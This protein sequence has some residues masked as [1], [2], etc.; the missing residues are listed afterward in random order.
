VYESSF[1]GSSTTKCLIDANNNIYILGIGT[2]PNGQVTKVKKISSSGLAV[3]SYFDS[4]IGGPITFKFTP[5]NKIVIVHRG[6]TGSLNGYSKIDLSGNNIW[7]IAG[8]ASLSVGDAAG[9]S[10]GNTFIINGGNPGS[11]L[12]KISP[13]GTILWT[14][15]NFINGNKV[16]V[17]T[18]N[19]PVV[20]GFASVGYGVAFMKY[21]NNGNVLWQNLDADGPGL[22]FLALAPMKL[23]ASNAAY[24][25]GSTMSLMG[26]CKVNSNGT[27]AWAATTSSGY[28]VC[29]DFGTD[30]SV[31][32]TGGTTARF[33]QAGAVQP[34]IAPTNLTAVASGSSVINLSWTD[35]AINETSYLV[36]RSLISTSGFATIA[37]L[38]ANSI[39]YSNTG[40]AGSTTYYYR[41]KASNSGVN[42]AN[43]N[44]ATAI[45]ATLTAPFAPSNLTAVANGCNTIVLTWVDNSTTE[46]AFKVKRSTTLNGSYTTIATL[47]SN[48]TTFANL[49]LATGNKYYY[50]VMAVNSAGNSPLSNKANA[51]ASCLAELTY[52]QIKTAIKLF[53]N[54]SNAGSVQLILSET[55][56][57]PVTVKLYSSSGSIIFQKELY[58]FY[59]TILTDKLPNGLYI[60]SV[61]KDGV[62]ESLK[63]QIIK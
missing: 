20:G 36:Q 3:W 28:P 38:P 11:I 46:T 10:F 30:N 23:D 19:N 62:V 12:K 21:D 58:D 41:I 61:E 52:K 29:M 59:N 39:S 13:T 7:S 50:R 54:P 9:D 57:F 37:T 17:G 6:I 43:S 63:L 53:P 49:S 60:I 18:D 31:Y 40:L 24:L 26:L 15:T 25:A 2:G 42:S 1:D 33:T 34:P 51:T 8:V 56:T 35:N 45:T 44:V 32:V 27:S 14:Q 5:D 47:T 55:T 22:V 4:G 16:E 48:S